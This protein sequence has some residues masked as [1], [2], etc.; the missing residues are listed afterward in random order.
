[1]ALSP[2]TPVSGSSRRRPGQSHGSPSRPAR[3]KGP[4]WYVNAVIALLVAA[5]PVVLAKVLN[6]GPSPAQSPVPGPASPSARPSSSGVPSVP[7]ASPSPT[8]CSV[9]LDH[10][11]LCHNTVDAKLYREPS[12]DSPVT[13]MLHTTLSWF[14]CWQHG[15]VHLGHNDIWYLTN[16]AVADGSAGVGFVAAYDVSTTQDP[17]PGLRQCPQRT[18]G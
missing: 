13:G 2:R 10:R 4:P 5:T 16:G 15:Q 7:M 17:A 18:P 1:M 6:G 12:Y 3:S 11:L 14:T 8:D 9:H